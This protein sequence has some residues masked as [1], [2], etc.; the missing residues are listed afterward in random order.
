MIGSVLLHRSAAIIVSS[1]F[2]KRAVPPQGSGL[3][4]Q[5]QKKSVEALI[6]GGGIHMCPAPPHHSLPQQVMGRGVR[7]GPWPT[8]L[9]ERRPL[10]EP[11]GKVDL[12]P[13]CR[14]TRIPLC[15]AER[16]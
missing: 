8:E 16:Y 3:N 6:F 4:Q 10:A 5:T 12:F 7:R 15:L 14:L 13:R 2:E 11:G 1:E 9:A